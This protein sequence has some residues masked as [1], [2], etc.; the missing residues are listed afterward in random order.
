[1]IHEMRS[2]FGSGNFRITLGKLIV[3]YIF[4]RLIR[5]KRCFAGIH[6]QFRAKRC[7][8]GIHPLSP[9]PFLPAEGGRGAEKAK[10]LASMP[11]WA[12]D[13]KGRK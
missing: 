9:G 1:M 13:K 2:V 8:A 5:A 4:S 11:L 12:K 3:T 10:K 7:F 6:P